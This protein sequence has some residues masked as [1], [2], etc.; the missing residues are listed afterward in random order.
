MSFA[1][2]IFWLCA[3][4]L[5]LL[6]NLLNIHNSQA[7]EEWLDI[8]VNVPISLPKSFFKWYNYRVTLKC[9]HVAEWLV[10]CYS[11]KKKA[12]DFL[13]KEKRTRQRVI[14]TN[15]EAR[16]SYCFLFI[17]Y[18]S[19]LFQHFHNFQH[20]GALFFYCANNM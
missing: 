4:F 13:I 19:L 3:D 11:S 8:K 6:T 10:K 18:I 17:N 2:A 15:C 16:H 9:I 7:L 20:Y 1:V 14:Y 5:P 12:L